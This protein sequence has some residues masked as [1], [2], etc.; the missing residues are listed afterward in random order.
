MPLKQ[1]KPRK[2]SEPMIYFKGTVRGARQIKLESLE[3]MLNKTGAHFYNPEHAS[4]E[5]KGLLEHSISVATNLRAGEAKLIDL[6]TKDGVMPIR[7]KKTPSGL[8]L[9][10]QMP[11]THGITATTSYPP[12]ESLLKVL[13]EGFIGKNTPNSILEVRRVRNSG[14]G[15]TQGETGIAMGDCYSIEANA[16]LRSFSE[17]ETNDY[18]HRISYP[19]RGYYSIKTA[20]PNQIVSINILLSRFAN[21]KTKRQKMAFY[22]EQIQKRFGIPV[23]F[24]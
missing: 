14:W 18:R 9:I 3:R 19:A 1:T 16:P 22:K 8:L 10:H 6:F 17:E 13:S 23:K 20:S 2:G 15:C 11:Q 7:I 24:I 5:I 4:T 12:F 21:K